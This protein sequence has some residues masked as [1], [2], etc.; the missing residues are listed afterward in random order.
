MKK[1]ASIFL[2]VSTLLIISCR[3][4]DEISEIDMNTLKAIEK[5]RKERIIIELENGN[6]S[7]ISGVNSGDPLPPPRK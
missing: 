4:Q 1:I 7:I 6:T 3:Q 5:S 2:G